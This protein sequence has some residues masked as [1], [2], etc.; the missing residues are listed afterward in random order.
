MELKDSYYDHARK[1][2]KITDHYDMEEMIVIGIHGNKEDL[3]KELR[4]REELSDRKKIEE[5]VFEG[6][7]R[8]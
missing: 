8:R 2:L 7:F 4:E 3:P 1:D 6:E 5:F